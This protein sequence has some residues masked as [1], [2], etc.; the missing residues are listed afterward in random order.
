MAN[1]GAGISLCMIAKNEAR[2][3][4]DA[5]RS[6]ADVVDEIC[7]VDT[8]STDETLAI[9]EPFGA[10]IKQVE[11]RDDFAWARNEALAMAT[12]AWILV[13]DA[14]ERLIETSRDELKAVGA[15]PAGLRGKWIMCRNLNDD[16]KG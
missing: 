10:K 15:S 14:D 11:W 6:V 4:S 13:L 1:R 16:V 8:G 12:R 2:F 3:L 5:L 7:I 9:A